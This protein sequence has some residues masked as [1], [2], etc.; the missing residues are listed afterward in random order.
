MITDLLSKRVYLSHNTIANISKSF[1]YNMA[2]KTSWHRYKTNLRHSHPMYT[3]NY[4]EEPLMHW[5][6]QYRAN[7]Y[8]F[9]KRLKYSALVAGSRR[10]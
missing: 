1:T 6:N 9:S 5:M 8:V 4:Y 2:A 3:G 7:K 10:E